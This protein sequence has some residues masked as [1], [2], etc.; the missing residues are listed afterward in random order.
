[1]IE[2]LF[3]CFSMNLFHITCIKPAKAPTT[4]EAAGLVIRSLDDPIAIPP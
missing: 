3:M 4:K 1:M 2:T